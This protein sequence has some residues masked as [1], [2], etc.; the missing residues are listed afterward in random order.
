QTIEEMYS[1]CPS[2]P[3][4]RFEKCLHQTFQESDKKLNSIYRAVMNHPYIDFQRKD[5]IRLEQRAWVDSRNNEC[6]VNDDLE[7]SDGTPQS[8][9]LACLIRYTKAQTTVLE[10]VWSVLDMRKLPLPEK[11]FNGLWENCFFLEDRMKSYCTYEHIYQ[12]KNDLTIISE[13]FASY[14]ISYSASEGRVDETGLL[15]V[16]LPLSG[17]GQARM[18]YQVCERHRL[19]MTIKGKT[20]EDLMNNKEESFFNRVFGYQ[21]NM[22]EEVNE[23]KKD[24]EEMK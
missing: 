3:P 20:C 24:I 8:E 10:G 16:I 17:E 14:R 9:I 7:P 18:V 23:L 6:N 13:E 15:A 4:E 12:N 5:R 19:Y 21:K 22:E 11:P 1:Q 2:D